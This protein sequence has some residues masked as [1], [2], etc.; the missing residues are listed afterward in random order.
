MRDLYAGLAPTLDAGFRLVNGPYAR[1]VVRSPIQA[2]VGRELAHPLLVHRHQH[3]ALVV[4]K[5]VQAQS[6]FGIPGYHVFEAGVVVKALQGQ[7]QSSLTHAGVLLTLLSAISYQLSAISY[8]LSATGSWV[9]GC[10]LP[11]ADSLNSAREVP[12]CVM[13]DA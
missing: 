7:N 1:N 3:L 6:A 5:V 4:V 2:H 13:R 12:W 9:A 10:R 8:Q 11:A